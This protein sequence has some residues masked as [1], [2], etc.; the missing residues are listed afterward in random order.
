MRV[1]ERLYQGIFI[2]G[3]ELP[4]VQNVVIT[5]SRLNFT[6][7]AVITIPNRIPQKGKKI[8]DLIVKGSYVQ[9]FLGYHP[10]LFLE[11]SG[12][13]SQVI[14]EKTATILCE[15]ESYL[16]KRQSI[17]KDLILKTTD[18]Q[19]L[20]N[21]IY[22]GQAEIQ[23]SNIGDWKISKNSTLLDVLSELQS[24]FKVYSYFRNKTLIVGANADT[25]TK[26]TITADFQ[27][28]LPL[29][30]SSLNFKKANDGKI[31]VKASSVNRAGVITEIYA[32][33]A[34]ETNAV[35]FQTTAPA[36]G[37]VNEFKIGG[38][39]GLTREDL[40]NLAEIRL[41]A[42]A[43]Q[44]I[45]GS[46]TMYGDVSVNHGDLITIRDREI[47]E[48]EGTFSVVE[49]VKRFGTGV[50]YRQDVKLGITI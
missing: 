2:D 17:G 46:V 3:K 18:I 15:N 49:V 19:T 23:N 40:E 22:I 39:S 13:V 50:G 47:P 5:T 7:T 27:R 38:Q 11:F 8:S 41:K 16:Y 33:F 32:F 37:N 12:Y 30:E 31:I 26:Q 6:D 42:L 34:D 29:G 36:N 25:R 24:K 48:R 20:I 28:N 1:H 10:D 21:S 43:F 14:P 44:G 45:D 9:I 35:T 4:F